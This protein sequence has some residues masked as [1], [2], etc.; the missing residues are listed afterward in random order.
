MRFGTW[1]RTAKNSGRFSLPGVCLAFAV[2]ISPAQAVTC[3][4]KG[5]DFDFQSEGFGTVF[6]QGTQAN[7]DAAYRALEKELGDPADYRRPTVFYAKAGTISRYECTGEK[8]SAREMQMAWKSCSDGAKNVAEICLPLAVVYNK[9]LYCVL[10][11]NAPMKPGK[12][13]A[14]YTPPFNR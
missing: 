10:Q 9:R 12:P 7:A 14:P 2:A 3:V 11:P 4:V 5:G 6:G 13:F 1:R 8:C